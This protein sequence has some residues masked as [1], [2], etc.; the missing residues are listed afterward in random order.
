MSRQNDKQLQEKEPQAMDPLPPP[1]ELVL[2]QLSGFDSN[3]QP[4]VS[5]TLTKRYDSISAL[6][7]IALT[8]QQIGRQ[9]GLLFTQNSQWT[10]IIVGVVHNALHNILDN[11][12]IAEDNGD[13]ELFASPL[14]STLTDGKHKADLTLD[15]TNS[16]HVDGK[17]IILEGE[18]QVVLRCGDASITLHKNGKIS[19]RGKYL[20]NRSSGVNRI[21]GGSVQVN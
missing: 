1:G 14:I 6:A 5:F 2:G 17:K 7:T 20:L 16:V 19:I 12:E 9:V 18:E 21:M 3:G 10:P 8:A 11:I 4:L 13:Q 15:H